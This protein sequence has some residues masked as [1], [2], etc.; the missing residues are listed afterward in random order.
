MNNIYIGARYVPKFADPIEWDREREYESLTVVMHYGS[1]YTSKKAVP[2]GVDILNTEYWVLTGNYNA[3]SGATGQQINN[4]ATELNNEKATRQS[5]DANLTTLINN[6]V[7]NRQAADSA[8]EVE[9]G[10]RLTAE[11]DPAEKIEVS[12]MKVNNSICYITKFKPSSITISCKNG[13]PSDPEANPSLNVPVYQYAYEHPSI[14]IVANCTWN[15]NAVIEGTKWQVLDHAPA[16]TDNCY[17][18]IKNGDIIIYETTMTLD[19]IIADGCDNA[20]LSFPP[21]IYNGVKANYNAH[22]T[23]RVINMRHP[24]QC[25]GVDYEGNFYIISIMGRSVFSIGATY[26]DMYKIGT[27]LGLK[28]L[29]NCDGGGSVATCVNGVPLFPAVDMT[30]EAGLGRDSGQALILKA[31]I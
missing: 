12:V 1:S 3:Q 29:A 20:F 14:N 4:L 25:L 19:A 9:I 11:N 21:I 22:S 28:T 26:D 5:A 13:N 31:M 6:E 16:T 24:R 2:S 27:L 30:Y 23:G 18:G 7:T 17:V 15:T 10:N 8:L